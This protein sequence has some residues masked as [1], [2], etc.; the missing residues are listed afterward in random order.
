MS[1][2]ESRWESYEKLTAKVP[3]LKVNLQGYSTDSE[4]SLRQYMAQEFERAVSFLCKVHMQQN[5]Q[6]KCR[7]LEMSQR[8]VDTVVIDIFGSAGLTSAETEEEFNCQLDKLMSKWDNLEN[9]DTNNPPKFSRYFRVYKR[10]DIWYHVS[11]KASIEAGFEEK[12]QTNN[13]PESANALLKRWQNFQQKDMSTFVDD[14]K[15]LI[16]RQNS[17]VKKAFLGM[18]SPYIVRPE[19]ATYVQSSST[20]FE[21]KPGSRLYADKIIIDPKRYKEVYNFKHAPPNTHA[22]VCV[23]R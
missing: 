21:S 5:I 23:V 15:G 7:A 19:Y 18:D 16:D 6:D 11:A 2:M 1:Y 4:E 22:N 3:G 10:D 9:A 17:D 20:F 14:V 8:A 13:V 12:L